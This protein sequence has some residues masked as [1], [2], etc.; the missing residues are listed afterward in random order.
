[1]SSAAEIEAAALFNQKE[2]VSHH[3][4]DSDSSLDLSESEK[5]VETE[6]KNIR[7]TRA[8]Q[9][10]AMPSSDYHLPSNKFQA[11]TG[12]KGVIA[13]AHAFEQAKRDQL[14]VRQSRTSGRNDVESGAFTF[15]SEKNNVR[16]TSSSPD[17][18]HEQSFLQTWRE[19]RLKELKT[20][21]DPRTRRQSPSK[22]RYRTLETVDAAGYLDAV[23]KV[24]ADT[25]VVVCISDDDSDVSKLVEDCLMHLARKFD[26]TRFVKLHYDEAEMDPVSIPALLVYRE[27]DLV[28]KLMPLIDEIPAGRDLSALSLETV[29]KK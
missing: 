19:N 5:E 10:P 23:E 17:E 20:G 12:P 2:T 29:L 4:E 25:T 11:N 9:V 13:D 3:P 26:T 7:G 14:R 15:F 22:R 21:P 24:P 8:S 6:K 27:G 28:D 18:H 16:E 1:M